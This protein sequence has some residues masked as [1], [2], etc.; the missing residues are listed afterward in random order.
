MKKYIAIILLITSIGLAQK[1]SKVIVSFNGGELSPLMDARIDQVKYLSGCRTMENYIPLIYG[2]AQRRPGTEY[3]AGCKSNSAKSRLIAFE[4]SVDDTY[5]LEFAN[6]VIR[7][8]RDGGQVLGKVGTE[9][10]SSL[11]N[12]VAHWLMNDNTAS[13]VV[14]DD[15]GGTHDADTVTNNTEDLHA[16]GKVGT[17][18]LNLDGGDAVTEADAATLSFTDDTDDEDFSIAAW[19]YVTDAGVNQTIVSKWKAG[20]LREYSFGINEDK[21]LIFRLSDDSTS[22]S[23]DRVAHWK[24]NETAANTEVHDD[25]TAGAYPDPHDG[26]SSANMNTL[27]ATGKVST[28]LDAGGVAYVSVADH[29]EL[30]FGNATVDSPFSIS[31]WIY[32]SVTASQQVI[33]SKWDVDDGNREWYLALRSTGDLELVLYDESA[34]VEIFKRTDDVLSDG[35]RFV[36]ATYT[37]QSATGSTAADLITLY[38]DNV[39]VAQTATNNANYDAMENTDRSVY[40]GAW[41]SGGVSSIFADKL[42]N[43]T[44][45]DVELSA[46][47][48]NFLWNA[49][50]GTEDTDGGTPYRLADTALANGWH[51]VGVTYD[52]DGLGNVAADRM[53]LYADGAAVDSTATNVSTYAAMEDTTTALLI[54]AEYDSSDAITKVWQDKLDN[55]AMFKDVLT[56]TEIASLYSTSAHETITP[57]LTADLFSLKFEQ[58]ADV[59]FITHPDY[60]PRKLSRTGHAEWSLD[61]TDIQTGPFRDENTTLSK[62]ITPSATTGSI[63]LTA[64][65]H[66]PFILGT[67]GHEPSGALATSKSQT[68]ALFKIVHATGTPSV[69]E[70][71]EADTLNDAT[72][73]LN[74]PKGV[75]WDFTTNGSWGAATDPAS[76]VLERSYDSG[77]TYETLVTVTSAANKNVTTSGTEEVADA[78]YRARTSAACA[79]DTDCSA[80]LSV[81]DTSHIG[82][83]EITSVTS[84]TVATGT[85]LKTLGSTDLTHRW[86]EGSFS[87]YRGWPIDVT[88]SAEERLTL[89]GN[90]S[91]PLTTWGSKSGDFTDFA[92]GTLDDDSIAFTLVGTGQQNRIRWIL[93]KDVLVIGTVGGEHLLGASRDDEALTPTNVRARLQTT[94]GSKDIAA[95]IVNQAILFVQRGGRKIRELLYEFESDSYK[96]DDLTVFANH[97]TESGIVDMDYQRTPD[98]MLWC[99]RDDGE[100]A[101]MSYERKQ[102]VFSWCRIVTST[103]AGTSTTTDSDFESVAVIYGGANSEDEVWVTVARTID[104]NTVRYV[105]RF[106]QRAMPDDM[107]DMKYLDSFLTYD[108]TATTTI[109]GLSHLEGET[110]Q[111]LGDGAV[112][113]TKTVSG[114]SI[115]ITSASTVQVGLGYTSTLKPMKLDIG[116]TSLTTT[117]RINRAV[118]NLFETIQGEIGPSTS[119]LNTITTGTSALFTGSKEVS[120]KGGYSREGDIL[121]QQTDPLPSTILSLNLDVGVYND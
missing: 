84:P 103:N 116:G 18:C 57:Y 64:I 63:T 42:D 34:N 95:L 119:K 78:I 55:V 108:S 15:D 101:V 16:T 33:L 76:V 38:V 92:G 75:T 111:V 58:S 53:I 45:F 47:N 61:A 99:V 7:V 74:V 9:D 20:S 22:L 52:G 115:T 6:Q 44:L 72:T 79:L 5:I 121:I 51:F 81:R 98:P 49:G 54:G 109:T 87:N 21:K 82:I 67:A 13:Q 4:H 39:A 25:T 110:V 100:M 17:G 36:V 96:A 40:I 85:V 14:L 32:M 102:N 29:A 35:W 66:S 3:I 62:T 106:F 11:N 8:F 97:I 80:Q 90:K 77:T 46:A 70:E 43:I 69:S 56:S 91:E 31:A 71:L 88:I 65:G 23:A 10:I 12:I 60:E 89:V 120:L 50:N 24:L 83:V 86:S 117:K 30:S 114:G 59:M 2:A 28:C 73:T 37:G 112:Q 26:T 1:T 107:N 105:E 94:H 19:A 93:S 48:I 113:A 118:V 27:T 41:V 68:G 104:S